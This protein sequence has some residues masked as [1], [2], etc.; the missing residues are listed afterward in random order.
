MIN[1]FFD[2]RDSMESEMIVF[3][4]ELKKSEDYI[5]SL[6]EAPAEAPTLTEKSE[7]TKEMKLEE[8]TLETNKFIEEPAEDIISEE[9]TPEEVTPELYED[10]EEVTPVDNAEEPVKFEPYFKTD[11]FPTLD[12][13]QRMTVKG[14]NVI[15]K[16]INVKAIGKKKDIIKK[17]NNKIKKLRG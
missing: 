12:E 4:T 1:L 10:I 14:L 9:V 5:K 13:L 6:N 2:S 11:V 16:N 3:L 15:A 8:I 17:I 7:D